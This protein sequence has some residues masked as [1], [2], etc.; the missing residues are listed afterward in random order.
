MGG[1]TGGEGGSDGDVRQT[2][3]VG[4]LEKYGLQDPVLPPLLKETCHTYDMVE[5][6]KFWVARHHGGAKD[7]EDVSLTIARLPVVL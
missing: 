3:T 5:E 7:D 2:H 1:A 4:M 6:S